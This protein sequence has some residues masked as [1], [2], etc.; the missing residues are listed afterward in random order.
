MR[1][2]IMQPYFFPNLAHFALIA[3]TDSWVVFDVTQYTRKSW[4]SRNR[5][6]HPSGGWNYITV[7]LRKA[8]L[9][10]RIHEARV[11]DMQSAHKSM[12]G[13][14]GHYRQDA[15]F[16]REVLDLVD[17][18]FDGAGEDSLVALNVSG[19]KEVCAYL[20][21]PFEYRVCSAMNL[22][23]PDRLG[24]GGWAPF[25]CGELGAKSYVNP[26]GGRALF[27]PSDFERHGTQLC[28][29]QF[30]PFIYDTSPFEFIEGLSILDVLMWNP[31]GAVRQALEDNI[32]LE[33]VGS[34]SHA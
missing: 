30:S 1:L 18:V 27:D 20:D 4:M 34:L 32:Q 26:P 12:Q 14:L 3:A 21:V 5:I 8:S 9:D 16:F 31:P 15:P 11:A 28:I 33:V 19:L 13:K 29:A 7:P 6:L 22:E 24:P 10:T 2:G 17:R 25:I 23:F